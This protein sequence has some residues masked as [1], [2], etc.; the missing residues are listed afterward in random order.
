MN[1]KKYKEIPYIIYKNPRIGTYAAY[2]RIPNDHPY[3]KL[4][5]KKW[6][7]QIGDRPRQYHYD[8]DAVPL[9]AH[10]GLTFAQ[11]ITQRKKWPQGFTP[12]YWVG[13]DYAHSEDVIPRI[14]QFFPDAHL[15]TE[16][17]VEKECKEVIEHLMSTYK[18]RN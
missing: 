5:S 15:W 12:G 4:V 2:I 9:E 1:M 18:L 10:G 17:E 14:S 3:V 6:W 11:H 8:Y 7:D 13:W 16:E